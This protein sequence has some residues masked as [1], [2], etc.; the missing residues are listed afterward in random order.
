MD[1]DF[2]EFF[3]KFLIS[4]GENPDREGLI[5]TPK[6]VENAYKF[7]LKGYNENVDDVINGALF[8]S[9]A[10]EMIIVK[11][12]VKEGVIYADKTVAD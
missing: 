8:K 11:K 4:I 9:E 1:I 12:D 6:R 5:D 3:R 7:L 10:S 2:Q